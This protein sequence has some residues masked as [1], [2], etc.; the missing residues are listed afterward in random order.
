MEAVDDVEIFLYGG[1][2]ADG[3]RDGSLWSFSISKRRWTRLDVALQHIG[4]SVPKLSLHAMSKRNSSLIVF[5]GKHI[6][7]K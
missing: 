5:G 6:R 2:L 4:V 1:E 7:K 3:T